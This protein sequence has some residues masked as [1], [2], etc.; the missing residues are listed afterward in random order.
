MNGS[1]PIRILLVDDNPADRLLI[2]ELLASGTVKFEVTPAA[3]L[4]AGLER[5]ACGKF[6]AVLLDLSLTDSSGLDSFIKMHSQAPGVPIVVL[7][8]LADEQT[9]LQA[10]HAGAQD[11]LVKDQID[12][13]LLT[14]S[15]RYSIERMQ[16]LEQQRRSDERLRLVTD[17]LPAI[18]WTTDRQLRF[19]SSI[20][21][22]LLA[23]ALEPNQVLGRT[24]YDYFGTTDREYPPIAAH[25]RAIS[26]E[27]VS[28]EFPWRNQ[29]FHV[30]VEPLKDERGN[31]AG[32]IGVALDV[33]DQKRLAE[34]VDAARQV[35][36]ALFPRSAP[37]LPGLEIAG[38]V[39]C[40]E[41][42]GGDYFDYIQMPEGRL[43]VVVGDVAGHGLGPALLMAELRAYLRPLTITR[44]DP[45][46]ILTLANQFL[47]ADLQEHCFITVFFA[48]LD[49]HCSTLLY[50]GAG[51]M[52]FV[53][54][55]SGEV[56]RLESTGFPIGL[57]EGDVAQHTARAELHPGDLLLVVTDGFQ[58]AHTFQNDLFGVERVVETV[59]RERT[60]PARE[61]VEVLYRAVCDF[62]G[63]YKQTDD[64]TAV[65]VKRTRS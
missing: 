38:N 1:Q 54:R 11:Y 3:N 65:V 56:E 4:G 12:R 57:M 37:E 28:I 20:G 19:T 59:A 23:L 45:G 16:A 53:I 64:M 9:A 33:S 18:L 30:H 26:G 6:D 24:L 29:A 55:Q 2:E 34:S 62:V 61:I 25:L 5:L 44:D 13:N 15:I 27:S 14:R 48:R 8:G 22:G 21:T 49:P 58:E 41:E 36:R 7:T 40:A 50:A 10:M 51:H 39:F 63:P 42:T 31:I 43:A 60:R 47:T 46:E 52:G 32:A 17:Q 35:Q